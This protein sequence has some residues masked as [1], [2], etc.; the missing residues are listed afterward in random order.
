MITICEKAEVVHAQ[1]FVTTWCLLES[2]HI[3]RHPQTLNQGKGTLPR[4]YMALLD[5]VLIVFYSNCIHSLPLLHLFILNSFMLHF[6]ILKMLFIQHFFTCHI[7]YC[8]HHLF[9]CMSALLCHHSLMK[10][11]ACYR[12]VGRTIVHFWLVRTK[13]W[14]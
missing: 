9:K 13:V 14:S 7:I 8:H 11:T 5:Y 6:I 12:N 10:V 1:P 3:Q 2:W 4:E